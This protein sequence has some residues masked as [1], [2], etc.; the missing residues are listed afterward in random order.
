MTEMRGQARYFG[1][2]DLAEG[3]AHGDERG[4]GP[5]VSPGEPEI[6]VVD[7]V[8]AAV[9]LVGP[10]ED[11]RAGAAGP[12]RRPHLPVERRRLH[13]LAV[14][15]A[16][17]PDLGHDQRAVAGEVLQPRQVGLEPVRCSRY[18]LKHMKSRNGRS[19]YSVVG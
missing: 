15:A 18:T 8:A 6:P 17:E 1:Q 3:L 11:E 5:S 16:V 19:R 10:R 13:A 4:L 2:R 14:P 7:V 12:E 9:P